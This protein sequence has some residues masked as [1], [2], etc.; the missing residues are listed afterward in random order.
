ME[1]LFGFIAI[2]I[3]FYIIFGRKSKTNFIDKKKN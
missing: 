2:L 3:I 1:I